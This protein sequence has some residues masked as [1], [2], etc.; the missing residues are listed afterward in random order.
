M[1]TGIFPE[2]LKIAKIIPL[3]KSGDKTDVKNKRPISILSVFSKVF[4]RAIYK[5]LSNYLETN[6]LLIMQQHG[7]RPNKST[8]SALLNFLEPIYEAIRE[9]KKAI[10]IFI[11]FSKAFDCLNH[12][13]LLSKLENLGIKG[14]ALKLFESYLKSRQQLVF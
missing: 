8:E 5:R 11:D 7:F 4:E 6:N 13:I 3:H 9:K 1:K 2:Q 12:S 10:G 14:V